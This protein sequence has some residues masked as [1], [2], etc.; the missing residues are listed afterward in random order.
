MSRRMD[1]RSFLKVTGGRPRS[2]AAAFSPRRSEAQDKRTLV[3]AW[4]TDIDT[5]DPAHFKAIGGYVTV[6][7]CYDTLIGWKVR[8]IKDKPGFFRSQPAEWE[9]MIAES[10]STERDGATLVFKIRKGAKFPSG[11]PVTA[12]A[13]KYCFDRGLQSPG[14]MRLVIPS[15]IQVGSPDQFEV[16]DDYTFAI[17][18]NAPSPMALDVVTLSNN[19]IMDPEEVKAHATKDDPWAGRVDEAQHRRRRPLSPREERARR[20]GRPGGEPGILAAGAVLPADRPQV[21]AQRGRPGAPS[22][23]EGDRH[24]RGPPGALA[25]EREEPRGRAGA[26]GLPGPRHHL[27]LALH[28]RQQAA[29]RQREGAAGRELRHPHP[30]HP[31][32]RA[33]RVRDADEEPGPAPHP[34]V[35]RD[36][37]AATST[38][39]RRR[40]SS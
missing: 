14:Y 33:L 13:A 8:P 4:D 36:A 16:R 21:R 3:V 11:R 29:L 12:H 37:L 28:E 27:P 19:A 17:K 32:Q 10:W 23:E 6:A 22:Q 20:G 15:L 24:G 25:Q 30:G 9:P 39:S 34:G 2:A 35:Q 7:N 1:R 5:L 26:Q 31:A 40:S 38:T 18:M